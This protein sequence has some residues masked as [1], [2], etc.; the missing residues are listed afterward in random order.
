MCGA[1][2]IFLCLNLITLQKERLAIEIGVC[3]YTARLLFHSDFFITIWYY[4]IFFCMRS[5]LCGKNESN[6]KNSI[7]DP[8][9]ILC[10]QKWYSF[11]ASGE[12]D[13]FIDV[14]GSYTRSLC[15]WS[16]VMCKVKI[17]RVNSLQSSTFTRSYL[18]K[19][20]V[21]QLKYSMKQCK[22]QFKI[23][24]EQAEKIGFLKNFL[25]FSP[26]KLLQTS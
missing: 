10:F 26:N 15:D 12:R 24:V 16:S 17:L 8:C 1:F 23:W 25:F 11:I 21:Y 7:W 9:I 3:I 5:V 19:S 14:S 20:W 13:D 22:T 4:I 18:H 2:H 6:N